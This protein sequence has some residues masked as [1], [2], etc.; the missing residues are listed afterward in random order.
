MKHI[1][2]TLIVLPLTVS[3]VA[4]EVCFQTNVAKT[5]LKNE[6]HMK[7]ASGVVSGQLRMEVYANSDGKWVIVVHGQRGRSCIKTFGTNFEPAPEPGE[8]A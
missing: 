7:V 8:P 5:L 1:L 6:K 3:S 4:A 2:A